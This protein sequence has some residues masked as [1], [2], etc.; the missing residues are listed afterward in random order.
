MEIQDQVDGAGCDQEAVTRRLL[1]PGSR[2]TG[3]LPEGLA[4]AAELECAGGFSGD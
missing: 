1:R 2:A 3:L 4:L